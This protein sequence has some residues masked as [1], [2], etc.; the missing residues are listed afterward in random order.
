LTRP[1]SAHGHLKASHEAVSPHGEC[2]VLGTGGAVPAT[3]PVPEEGPA[4][5][6]VGTDGALV[7]AGQGLILRAAQKVRR[8]KANP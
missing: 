1:Q 3:D 5:F 6:L 2:G 7:D 8:Q 4:E